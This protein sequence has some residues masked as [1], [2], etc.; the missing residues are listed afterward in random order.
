MINQFCQSRVELH[1]AVEEVAA[2]SLHRD[3]AFR[4]GVA[5]I[6]HLKVTTTI[7]GLFRLPPLPGHEHRGQSEFPRLDRCVGLLLAGETRHAGRGRW[8]LLLHLLPLLRV[9][10]ARR[11]ALP[12]RVRHRLGGRLA[13][14]LLGERPLQTGRHEVLDR[15]P[16]RIE[17]VGMVLRT[18]C[19]GDDEVAERG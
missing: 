4:V 13:R 5:G 6:N 14:D 15:V 10:V 9:A 17:F 1:H 7:F 19:D 2:V 12:T 3:R 11:V 18:L 16:R 8:S